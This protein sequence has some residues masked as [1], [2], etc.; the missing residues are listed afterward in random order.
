MQDLNFRIYDDKMSSIS[1]GESTF[2]FI[3]GNSL[4]I[5]W[6]NLSRFLVTFLSR[7]SALLG[8]FIRTH[9]LSNNCE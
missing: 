3:G 1:V 8:R 7:M 5:G 2:S 4:K 6:M 9:L